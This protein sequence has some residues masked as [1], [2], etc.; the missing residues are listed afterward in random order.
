MTSQATLLQSH[1]TV[2]LYR[3]DGLVQEN[4]PKPTEISG[5]TS[6]RTIAITDHTLGFSWKEGKPFISLIFGN[7]TSKAYHLAGTLR[8]IDKSRI[9]IGLKTIHYNQPGKLLFRWHILLSGW[10]KDR[11]ICVYCT[12][13]SNFTRDSRDASTRSNWLSR[14]NR[15]AIA[16]SIEC[17][18]NANF[19][20]ESSSL[21]GQNLQ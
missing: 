6:S 12:T 13:E 3:C 17:G 21:Q 7:I 15:F 20:Y 8:R 10:A 1:L 5:R 2:H 19:H 11:A 4:G 9:V 14:W 18:I 16:E